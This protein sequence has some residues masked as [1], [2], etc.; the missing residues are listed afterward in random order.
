MAAA[1]R[2][3]SPLAVLLLHNVH[4]QARDKGLTDICFLLD[5]EETHTVNYALRK[6]LKAGPLVSETRGKRCS[7]RPPRRGGRFATRVAR[8]GSGTGSG[9]CRRSI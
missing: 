6:L 5:I 2:E 1:G 9:A 4:H 3:L 8:P 7:A